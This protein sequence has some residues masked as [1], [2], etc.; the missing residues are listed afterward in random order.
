MKKLDKWASHKL[1]ENQKNRRLEVCSTLLPRDKR[2]PFLDRIVTRD[3]K[4][5][6]HD[7]RR[8]SAQRLD[9]NKAPK[10][11]PKPSL[12]PTKIMVTVW[13]SAAGAIHYSF[14]KSG[15]TMTAKMYCR[16]LEVFHQKLSEK[17][18]ALV[19]RREPILLH[20]NAR[21]YIPRITLQKLNEMG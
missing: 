4:W 20:D 1:G 3:E 19:N 6:L 15:E 8:R 17:Q 21:P 14:I 13:W 12:D 2:E 16:R 9:C 7:N 5:S 18:P 11:M 10:H